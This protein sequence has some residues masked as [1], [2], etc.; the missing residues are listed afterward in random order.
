MNTAR[1]YQTYQ[2]NQVQTLSQ[3]KLVLMLYEGAIKFTVQGKEAC[4]KKDIEKTNYYLGR[5]QAILAELMANL[6]RDVGQVAENLFA[7]YE[8][9]YRRLVEANV[10]KDIVPMEEVAGMLRE[11]RDTWVKVMKKAETGGYTT[12]KGI[13]MQG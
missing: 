13:N 6:N 5:T 2:Q 11:L 12:Q 9:M 4:E 3:E 1:A 8:Y 7:L 10:K